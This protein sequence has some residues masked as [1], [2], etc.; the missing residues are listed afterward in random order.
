MAYSPTA[1]ALEELTVTLDGESCSTRAPKDVEACKVRSQASTGNP[2]V[3]DDTPG[4]Y[5]QMTTSRA[6]LRAVGWRGFDFRK[7]LVTIGV[8]YTNIQP[9]NNRTM[10]LASRIGELLEARGCK[11]MLACCPAISD[12]ITQ[13][14]SGMR[15][16]LVSREVI[17][18]AI[19]T[20]HEGY[21]ADAMITLSGCA[22]G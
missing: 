18:D 3:S 10:E 8:P 12:G 22:Q 17:T 13:G 19:E 2:L 11:F 1:A 7:P 9:C 20:M 15:Y 14:S 21:A 6:N 16:S 4:S 5:L